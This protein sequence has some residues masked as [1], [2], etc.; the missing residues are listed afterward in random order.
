MWSLGIQ[1]SVPVV[2][3]QGSSRNLNVLISSSRTLTKPSPIYLVTCRQATFSLLWVRSLWKWPHVLFICLCKHRSTAEHHK[4]CK[5][6]TVQGWIWVS[7][8]HTCLGSNFCACGVVV[9]G[10]LKKPGTSS[11]FFAKDQG[12]ASTLGEPKLSRQ[13]ETGILLS[14]TS[15]AQSKSFWKARK[16]V[17]FVLVAKMSTSRITKPF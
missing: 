9:K 5:G 8:H 12:K 7:M 10:A 15:S 2:A 3:S 4:S 6:S 13:R 11:N 1:Q 14:W 16:E 17:E